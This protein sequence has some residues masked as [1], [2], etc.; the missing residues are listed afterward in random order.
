M[1][2]NPLSQWEHLSAAATTGPW[3]VVEDDDG[4][5]VMSADGDL[6]YERVLD[7]TDTYTGVKDQAHHDAEFI[8]TVR[9]AIPALLDHLRQK[10]NIR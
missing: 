5:R 9:T 1:K 2:T 8:A 7:D 6:I 3:T 4:I 10:E